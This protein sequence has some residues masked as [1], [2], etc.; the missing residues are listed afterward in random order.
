MPDPPIHTE[1]EILSGIAAGDASAFTAV[2]ERFYPVLYLYAERITGKDIG[3]SQDATAEAFIEL[4][5]GRRQFDHLGHLLHFL[6]AIVYHKCVDAFRRQQRQV[7]LQEEL[8]NATEQ[9][10]EAFFIHEIGL[11]ASLM[12]RIRAEVESL[13]RHTRDVFLLAFFEHRK[14]AEI[15]TLLGIGDATVRRRKTEALYH[16]RRTLKGI[17][18]NTLIVLALLSGLP[19]DSLIF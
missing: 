7:L 14:N 2:Y 9:E 4:W 18:W 13:P 10:Q 11:E 6:R 3:L 1:K 5:K 17:D 19:P 16:L 12:A 15:A 8:L